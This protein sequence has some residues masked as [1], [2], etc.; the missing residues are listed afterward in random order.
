M[1]PKYEIVRFKSTNIFLNRVKVSKRNE[2]I[3]TVHQA[4]DGE[5]D[6]AVFMKDRSVFKLY[7]ED[8]NKHLMKCFKEDL[9]FSKIIK[10]ISK[11][12][13]VEVEFAAITDKLFENYVRIINIFDYYSGT[14]NNYPTISM[15]DFTSFAK[16]CKI[17]DDSYINLSQ[18]DLLLVATCV[19]NN[20]WINSAEKDLQRYEFV[21]MVVRL[22]NFRYV[23]KGL[24]KTTVEG[25]ERCL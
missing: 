14:S 22:A 25:I 12:M 20:E 23:E 2:D 17:L 8:S 24:V 7:N 15:N 3:E 4:R 11:K 9:Q 19:S 16:Q 5:D 21:E 13:D 18:L 1:S 6:E 10:T